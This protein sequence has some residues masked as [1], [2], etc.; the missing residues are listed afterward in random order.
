MKKNIFWIKKL[1]GFSFLLAL[2]LGT[3]FSGAIAQENGNFFAGDK[4]TR[5]GFKGGVNVSQLYVDKVD[6]NTERSK[7]GWHA[8]VFLKAPVSD[9]FAFQPEL[10]YSSAG[11]KVSYQGSNFFGVRPGEVR[12][13]LNYLQLPLLGSF[14]LGPV[15]LQIG[16]YASYLL[17]ANIRNL[18]IDDPLEPTG[19]MGLNEADFERFD[20]GLAGGLAIDVK[21][22][23]LGARYNYGLRE[24]SDKG[25]AGKLVNNS[26]NSVAQIFVGIAF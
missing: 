8:G 7:W 11:T 26:K 19:G 15:S 24:I 5:F 23:Q 21:G 20:Y 14:T 9:Y 1:T 3:T 12:Y 25:L 18:Q 16:P 22:F 2:F 10:L 4:A 17:D 6:G 13:N